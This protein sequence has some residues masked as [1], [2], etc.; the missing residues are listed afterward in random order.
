MF[1]SEWAKKR[2][3]A[4]DYEEEVRAFVVNDL[5]QHALSIV[6]TAAQAR[7]HGSLISLRRAWSESAMQ[8][9]KD[10]G[11]GQLGRGR[12]LEASL[13][14][15][16]QA[17]R[18]FGPRD[19]DLWGLLAYFPDG[20]TAAAWATIRSNEGNVNEWIEAR[21]SLLRLNVADV[22]GERL[23]LLAP[24]RQFIVERIRA[25]GP[26]ALD[27][28]ATIATRW[29]AILASRPNPS[30]ARKAPVRN[31]RRRWICCWPTS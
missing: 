27:S 2:G 16:Y 3:P 10:R 31:T 12:S 21:S 1:T 17:A 18:G 13:D 26:P 30:G 23:E 9:A 11:P 8:V 14:L 15:S 24:L 19:L 5:D 28:V 20:L 6:L 29:F 22:G 25:G 4:L 7:E